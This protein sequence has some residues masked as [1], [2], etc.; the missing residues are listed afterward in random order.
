M[1]WWW[2]KKEKKITLKAEDYIK[3]YGSA[4]AFFDVITD[5]EF[6]TLT[7]TAFWRLSLRMHKEIAASEIARRYNI[8]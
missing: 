6:E 5:E 1:K 7:W 8:K 4:V 3:K 2:N